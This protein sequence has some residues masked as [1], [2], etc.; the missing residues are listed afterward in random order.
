MR[1]SS[2]STTCPVV[3]SGIVEDS[4]FGNA[5]ETCEGLEFGTFCLEGKFP[6]ASLE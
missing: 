5:V 6:I 4:E 3:I 2:K 1:L